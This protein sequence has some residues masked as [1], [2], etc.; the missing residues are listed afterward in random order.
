MKSRKTLQRMGWFVGLWFASVGCL[1]IVAY[2]I[3]LVI[4]P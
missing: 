3:R 2:A 4:N 1:A